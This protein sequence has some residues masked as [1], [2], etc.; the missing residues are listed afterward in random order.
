VCI[1]ASQLEVLLVHEFPTL[2]LSVKNIE[3]FS[4][5]TL[6]Q[7]LS[8]HQVVDLPEAIIA[9]KIAKLL[10]R[11]VD[12]FWSLETRGFAVQFPKAVRLFD[13]MQFEAEATRDMIWRISC[14]TSNKLENI[15][16]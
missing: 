16:L 11:R 15:A 2:R 9:I 12:T 3:G 10:T 4:R 5:A 14:N 1:Y 7:S 13:L 8:S 6:F